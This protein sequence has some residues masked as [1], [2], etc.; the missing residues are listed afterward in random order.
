MNRPI[1]C[2]HPGATW[3]AK[4]WLSERFGELADLLAAK[5]GLQAIMIGDAKDAAEINAAL[6]HSVSNVKVLHDLPL[7]QLA[8][9]ISHCSL[10]VGNDAGPMHIAAALGTPTI[11]LFGPG[12]ENIWFPYSTTEGHSALRKDVP[13]HPCHLDF[14]NREGEGY[15]ECMKLLKVGEVFEAAERSLGLKRRNQNLSP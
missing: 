9:I 13:C 15:M 12:E 7:R 1:V 10:F 4:Q 3:P 6:K 11:G 14:C 2:I 5:L 8:A